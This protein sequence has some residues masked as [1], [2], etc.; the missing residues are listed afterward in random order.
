[1]GAAGTSKCAILQSS[2]KNE[3]QIKFEKA[4]T[5]T[6]VTDIEICYK[7]VDVHNA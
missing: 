6:E 2:D 3:I 4:D 1:M 7:Y 5:V